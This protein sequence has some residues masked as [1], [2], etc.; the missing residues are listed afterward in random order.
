[1]K[2]KKGKYRKFMFEEGN[3][4]EWLEDQ[5][6]K[7]SEE[8]YKCEISN[9]DQA[10]KELDRISKNLGCL[11][12]NYIKHFKRHLK[13]MKINYI[14]THDMPKEQLYNHISNLSFIIKKLK[15]KQNEDNKCD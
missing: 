8:E 6:K 10:K 5:F 2:E 3:F 7:I 11:P 15:E 4:D 14:K 13:S 1:M 9:L 12:Q